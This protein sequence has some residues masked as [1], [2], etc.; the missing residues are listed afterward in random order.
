MVEAGHI[1]RRPLVASVELI[2]RGQTQIV[3][4]GGGCGSGAITI[5]GMGLTAALAFEAIALAAAPETLRRND[6]IVSAPP[7]GAP[8]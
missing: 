4:D 5:Q 3:G 7:S 6:G 1:P 8:G 2:Q